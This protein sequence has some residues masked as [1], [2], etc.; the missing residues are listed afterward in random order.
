MVGEKLRVFGVGVKD[1]TQDR[2]GN[3]GVGESRKTLRVPPRATA[4]DD[5]GS[6]AHTLT[7]EGK[8]QIL[9]GASLRLH[10]L[11]RHKI[12]GGINIKRMEERKKQESKR[13]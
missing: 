1:S 7:S 11:E 9:R 12:R 10:W 2:K 4:H 13:R 5:G 6:P 3:R 8:T